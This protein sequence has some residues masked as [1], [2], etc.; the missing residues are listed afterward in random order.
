MNFDGSFLQSIQR[1]GIGGVIRDWNGN[2]LRNFSGP[3]DTLDANEAEVSA[4]LIGCHELARKAPLN[5][6]PEGGSFSSI[7]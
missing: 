3:V 7:Q 2:V 5:P 6:I 1:G 4:L